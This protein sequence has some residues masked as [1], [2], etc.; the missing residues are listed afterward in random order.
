MKKISK[1]KTAE[2]NV[3]NLLYKHK[4]QDKKIVDP[5]KLSN[6]TNAK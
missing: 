2:E 1:E 3:V 6:Y 4:N 5:Y